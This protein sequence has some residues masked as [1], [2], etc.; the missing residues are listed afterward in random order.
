[1]TSLVY[2]QQGMAK[3]LVAAGWDRKLHAFR[4]TLED[5]LMV[6]ASYPMRGRWAVAEPH[7]DDVLAMA[8]CPPK[9]VASAAYDGTIFVWNM[10]SA[11]VTGRFRAPSDD[12]TSGTAR[13]SRRLTTTAARV[14]SM[15]EEHAILS[16]Q[17]LTTRPMAPRVGNLVAGGCRGRVY[18]WSAAN[19]GRLIARFHL[20]CCA[21]ITA[22]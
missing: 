2:L 19:A 9:Y 12:F 22:P 6:G 4:D 8:Y 3:T 14:E 13:L 11:S 16:L 21:L 7:T 15:M 18:I 17:F 1:V 20:V 5:D 10:S